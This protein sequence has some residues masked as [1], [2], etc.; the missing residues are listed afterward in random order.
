MRFFTLLFAFV[1]LALPAQITAAE[2]APKFPTLTGRV[3]DDAHVLSPQTKGDLDQKLAALEAKTSRQLVVVTIASLQGYDI[4]D[5]GYQ[6]GRVWG[7]G[8]A[9]L[10]NG[11]LFIVAP[12]EH[13]VRIEVG[14][15]LE[16][17]IT[18]ALS[19]VIIQQAVLP[20]FRANDFNGGVEAGVDALVQQLSLDPSQAE[21]R[22]AA[23][24]RQAQNEDQ[25][26]GISPLSI[27]VIILFIAIAFGRIF[28]GFGFLPF[29]FMSGLG[30]GLGGRGYGGGGFGGG[31]F[32]GGGFGGGGGSFGG[33]G[34]SGSW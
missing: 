14:Y 11:V 15:G 29:L 33:G 21:A 19:E 1:V 22:A 7:I 27:L 12:N 17:I 28:R 10:N 6:L 4:A 23:V 26:S 31:G 2:A 9:K 8:Q 5:Y 34:A 16:P 32:G 3:V 25:G 30:S 18:D 13:R 24:A 20:K